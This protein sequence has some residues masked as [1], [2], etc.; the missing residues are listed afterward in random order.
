M[1]PWTT[2][3]TPLLLLG[4]ALRVISAQRVD[5]GRLATTVHDKSYNTLSVPD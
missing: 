3:V 4:V 2:L 5:Y 1:D